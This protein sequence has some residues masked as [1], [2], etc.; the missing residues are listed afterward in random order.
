KK[1][2]KRKGRKKRRKKER[3]KQ[4]GERGHKEEKGGVPIFHEILQFCLLSLPHT[5]HS[6][7]TS[8]NREPGTTSERT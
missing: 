4:R 6:P 5:H 1:K 2:K 3:K 7:F 8:N